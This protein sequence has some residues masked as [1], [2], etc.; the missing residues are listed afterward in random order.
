MGPLDEAI[1]VA[2]KTRGVAYPT[3][4][5]TAKIDALGGLGENKE[6]LAL[7]AEEMR[8]VSGYHLSGHLYEL[9]QTRAGVYM[10]MGQ[11][12]QGVS[13]FTQAVRYAKQLSNWRGLTQVDGSLAEAYLHQG[14][15]QPALASI[16]EAMEANKN[17]PDELY[18]APKNLATKAEIMARLGNTKA[19]NALYEK[20]AD[21]LD[22]LLS[23]VP[24][25]TVERQLL[26]DL[27]EVYS[28]YFAS[29]ST[30]GRTADAFRVIERARGRVEAQALAHHE[31]VTPHEPNAIEQHLTQLNL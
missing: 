25:P 22:A 10:R 3:I 24:T 6:A 28:G 19:S 4:A 26:S 13:D 8:R 20:S 11:W 31:V 16:D 30:Q 18:F 17:I 29:L 7:A 5:I 15:L 2:S 27:S 21:L 23:K 14:A 12:G 1:Q 9:Y